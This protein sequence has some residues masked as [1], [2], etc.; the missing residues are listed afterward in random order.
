[1][2]QKDKSAMRAAILASPATF[3]AAIGNIFGVTGN[4]FGALFV[5]GREGRPGHILGGVRL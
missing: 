4:I 1:L 2:S 3:L 5:E